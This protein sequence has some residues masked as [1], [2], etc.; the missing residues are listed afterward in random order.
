MTPEGQRW[1][2]RL[3]G[4]IAAR[5]AT[6]A[7]VG[8]GYIGLPI[9]AAMVEAGFSVLGLDSD[10]RKVERLARGE[11]YL[12][13]LGED[14]PQRLLDSGRFEPTADA[15]RLGEVDAVLVHSTRSPEEAGR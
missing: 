9:T 5:Q 2:D 6:V 1:A 8:L 11:A 15:G 3:H 4:R 13:H 7:V 10:E 14:L 12:R